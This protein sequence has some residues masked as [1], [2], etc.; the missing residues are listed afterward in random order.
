MAEDK[1][2]SVWA[3]DDG[4][5]VWRTKVAPAEG[6]GIRAM[7][8]LH[9]TPRTAAA[10]SASASAQGNGAF[11]AW[12]AATGQE[13]GQWTHLE[14]PTVVRASQLGDAGDGQRFDDPFVGH[15]QGAGG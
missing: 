3:V 6:M 10:L 7:R 11:G 13:R 9:F 2:V 12:D 4:R 14:I 8:R 5:E 1:A 15:G